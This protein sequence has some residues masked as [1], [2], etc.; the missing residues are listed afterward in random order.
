MASSP[1]PDERVVVPIPAK[2]FEEAGV[3][4]FQRVRV[5][6]WR[7]FG[8]LT[9]VG[10]SD[11]ESSDP[12]DSSPADPPGR[13]TE[14]RA[15]PVLA[16]ASRP[17]PAERLA[18]PAP[19]FRPELPVPRPTPT[20][21]AS[22][23]RPGLVTIEADVFDQ[24]RLEIKARLPYFQRC[25]DAARRRGMPDIRRLQATWLIAEDGSIK[26]LRLEGV[27]DDLLATCIIRMGSR[28]FPVSPGT[29]VT[30]PTPI[31]FVR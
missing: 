2:Q 19:G 4:L 3:R 16:P 7:G 15:A 26:D 1:P 17:Q 6:F 10:R 5:R 29:E 9:E 23:P 14:P 11:E 27:T 8:R 20:P 18:A 28:P 25:V 24:I 31:V 30:I 21:P 13:D 12:T 22:A